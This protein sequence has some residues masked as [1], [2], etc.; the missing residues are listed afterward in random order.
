MQNKS[1]LLKRG[2]FAIIAAVF[3]MLLISMM[4][5]KMLSYSTDTAS[6]T[7]NQYLLEQAQLLTYNATEFAVLQLSLQ[8]HATTCVTTLPT[9][10]YPASGSP[11]FD[12]DITISYVWLAG[13][14]PA[15]CVGTANLLTVNTPEQNGSA[16]IDVTVVSDPSLAL[17]APIRYHRRTLQKL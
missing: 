13:S 10:F 14:V 16:Y 2:G 15:A 4:L 5:L 12:I 6:R 7:V 1:R 3:L 8:N 9:Q 17:D 11:M